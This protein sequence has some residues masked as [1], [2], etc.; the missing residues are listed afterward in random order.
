MKLLR[1]D[2]KDYRLNEIQLCPHC[3]KMI[4]PD[5]IIKHFP[6]NYCHH[7]GGKVEY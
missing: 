7:C 3:E 2:G 1:R 6:C 4:C 5:V